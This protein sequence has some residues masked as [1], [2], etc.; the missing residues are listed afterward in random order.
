VIGIAV[1]TF[2]ADNRN[3]AKWAWFGKKSFHANSVY[4]A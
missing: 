2:F 4:Q 1:N 3:I